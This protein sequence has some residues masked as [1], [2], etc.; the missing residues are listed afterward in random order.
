MEGPPP[1]SD[2]QFAEWFVWAKREVTSDPR[3]CLGVAQAAV[4]AMSSGADRTAAEATARRSVAGPAVML[5]PKVSPWRQGYAEWY[6]WARLEF[7]GDTGR[8]HRLT[9]VAIDRLKV[10]GDAGHAAQAARAAAAVDQPAPRTGTGSPDSF[11]TSWPQGGSGGA[12]GWGRP[13]FTSPVGGSGLHSS[14]GPPVAQGPATVVTFERVAYASFGR[15]LGAAVIDAVLGL[16]VT[17]FGVVVVGVFW[18]IA[19]DS[20]REAS[21]DQIVLTVLALLVMLGVVWWV[22]DAG[23]ESSPGQATPGKRA[24]G[25]VV[26]D[27]RASRVS[28]GR[29][30]ARHFAKFVPLG[31]GLLALILGPEALAA[32]AVDPE[33]VTVGVIGLALLVCAGVEFLTIVL[34]R[35]R[36]GLHD[37]IAGTVVVRRDML[38]RVV[39]ATAA[40]SAAAQA[41]PDSRP[42]IPAG[43]ARPAQAPPEQGW[44]GRALPP[45]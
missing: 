30:T 43:A 3:V 27:K 35:Q 29:A 13:G 23:F 32:G 7:G 33:T 9:R 40:P 1:E 8:L 16:L 42:G 19:A 44:R 4:E 11:G 34:T 25:L 20:T 38:A 28:F 6:D 26:L 5:I 21:F 24:V 31:L 39:P 10:D 18:Y 17:V 14:Q 41:V 45:A 36:R 12:G 22:Y 2:E 15:R 37:L